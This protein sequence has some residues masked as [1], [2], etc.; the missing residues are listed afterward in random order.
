SVDAKKTEGVWTCKNAG[1]CW[2][3]APAGVTMDDCPRDVQGK[4]TPS[5]LDEQAVH[6]ADVVVGGSAITAAFAVA[7]MRCGWETD[8]RERYPEAHQLMIACDGGGAMGT[9]RDSGSLRASHWPMTRASPAP[10]A[11]IPAARRSGIPSRIAS[12]AR[13]AATG[14][15]SPC[16]PGNGCWGVCV[17]PP[18]KP[19]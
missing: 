7:C 19:V 6:H 4:A 11:I 1:A 18:Q 9:A 8:G 3:V 12:S 5:G 15:A 10:C 13:S 16:G 14:R 2:G 17:G